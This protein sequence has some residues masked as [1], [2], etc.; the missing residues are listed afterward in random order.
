MMEAPQV[1]FP[2]T[3][4]WQQANVQKS[5]RYTFFIASLTVVYFT[6]I[7]RMKIDTFL[8]EHRVPA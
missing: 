6:Q 8:K 4:S 1:S 5:G 2:D 7:C 3:L